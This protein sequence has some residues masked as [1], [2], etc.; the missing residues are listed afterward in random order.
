VRF[1]T[2]A[3]G[4]WVL[5]VRNDSDGKFYTVGVENGAGG[6]PSL[7]LSDEGY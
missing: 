5:Q 2:D 7:Y 4:N 6:E 3:N 1:T